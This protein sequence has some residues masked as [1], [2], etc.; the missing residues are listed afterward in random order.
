M[1]S[2]KLFYFNYFITNLKLIYKCKY[3]DKNNEN[4]ILF[5]NI[6]VLLL[7]KPPYPCC[8]IP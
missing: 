2:R 5:I 6:Y 7:H 3:S 8:I 4:L 1:F